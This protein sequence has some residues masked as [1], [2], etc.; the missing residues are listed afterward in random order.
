[1]VQH[2]WRSSFVFANKLYSAVGN[3]AHLSLPPQPSLSPCK[4]NW[5]ETTPSAHFTPWRSTARQFLL[6]VRKSKLKKTLPSLCSQKCLLKARTWHLG[7]RVWHSQRLGSTEASLTVLIRASHPTLLAAQSPASLALC[8]SLIPCLW[9]RL[10][11][12]TAAIVLASLCQ[13]GKDGIGREVWLNAQALFC[14]A[15]FL[16][17]SNHFFFLIGN[18]LKK[19]SEFLN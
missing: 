6:K 9:F 19:K 15:I 7:G 18:H 3:R 14:S 1:M 12:R 16:L 5:S 17:C 11:G 8:I 2:K 10:E 4:T 13:E